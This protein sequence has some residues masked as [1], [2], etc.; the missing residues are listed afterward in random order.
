MTLPSQFLPAD[1]DRTRTIA[2]IA[3]RE[4]YPK[5]TID[6]IRRAGIAVRLIAFEGETIA[7]VIDS[8]RPEEVAI[9]KVGQLGRLL[10]T[11]NHFQC[12][13][14]MMVGQVAPSRLFRGLHPDLKAIRILAGLKKRNAQT[15]FGAIAK[16]IEAIGVT[17]LDARAFLDHEIATVGPM[18]DVTFKT[19][20]GAIEHGFRIAKEVAHLDIGQSIVV[21]HG[22]VIAVEAFEGTDSMLRRA[23]G[24]KADDLIL[25]KVVKP[26]QDYRFDVPVFGLRTLEIMSEAGISTGCLEAGSIIILQKEQV[27]FEARQRGI[28]VLGIR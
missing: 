11:I 8:F 15:I 25:V 1:F 20:T 19:D 4:I 14:A 27:L 17:L 21:R 12:R 28:E 2:V 10:N 23:G 26:N 9:L 6:S 5:L 24:F 22:T 3:G 16:E 7:E 13:Y 18:T